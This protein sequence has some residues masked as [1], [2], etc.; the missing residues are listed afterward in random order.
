MKMIRR[1]L[2]VPIAVAVAVLAAHAVSSPG[3]S[4]K[5]FV[6]PIITPAS[7]GTVDTAS[8][9]AGVLPDAHLT[10]GATDPAV[11]QETIERTICVRGYSKSVRPSIAVT[12]PIK[13]EVLSRYAA[14]GDPWRADQERGHYE[15]DHL[16]SL[17]L[18]GAPADPANLW[19][20]P[21]ER[22]NRMHGAVAGTTVGSESKDRLEN[23]LHD[24]VCSGRMPLAAAQHA[25]ATNWYQAWVQAG[26]P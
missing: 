5:R 10:P 15:L 8:V 12:D 3:S 24:A 17:E 14:L 11:A 23:S 26:R 6:A 9:P 4:G 25:I 18:G 21:Y 2:L 22:P 1:L 19:P 13:R 16:I 7:G 20:E